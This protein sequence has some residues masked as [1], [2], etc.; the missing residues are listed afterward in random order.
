MSVILAELDSRDAAGTITTIRLA[1]EDYNHP[2]APG[3]YLGRLRGDLSWTR[4][5]WSNGSTSGAVTIG[6]GAIAAANPD[7]ALDSLLTGGYAGGACRLLWLEDAARPY[8]EAVTLARFTLEQPEFSFNEVSFRVRDRLADLDSR[9]LQ[10]A[11]YLGTTTT[12]GIE[13]PVDLKGKVKPDLYG[14]TRDVEPYQVNPGKLIYQARNGAAEVFAVYDRGEALTR[15]TPDYADLT[16]MEAAAPGLGQFRAC[17]SLGCFRLGGSPSGLITADVRTGA[18]AADR[19]VGQILNAIATGPGGLTGAEVSA[20]DIAA[21][22]SANSAVVGFYAREEISVR[23]A[24]EPIVNSIGAWFGFD[25]LGVLRA[26]R[27]INPTGSPVVSF[28]RLRAGYGEEAA[29]AN[30]AD[31]LSIERRPLDD[32][33]R[34]VPPAT[35]TLTHTRCWTPQTSDLAGAVLTDPAQTR[36]NFLATETR[37]A[38][39]T[40]SAVLLQFP[41]AGTRDFDSLIDDATDAQ[42]EVD[43]RLALFKIRRD[44]YV[45]STA[46]TPALIE[47]L[48]LGAIV[49]IRLPRFGLDAGKLFQVI[50]LT[51]SAGGEK[52]VI[53]VDVWG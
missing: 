27:L 13:G 52:P 23:A 30:A 35:C 6:F 32:P 26:G 2:T 1:T 42:T 49:E 12:V 25:R 7:G 41:G 18:S 4:S 31:I 45:V 44:R 53:E 20:A 3:F 46:L 51:V 15:A 10:T 33:G 5:C 38:T 24:L 14:L 50:G 47:A 36:R 22:D 34:G 39:A 8:T 9:K 19:T 48:E 17:P 40:D 43:R 16:A 37:K 29:P 28:R 21:L 11:R